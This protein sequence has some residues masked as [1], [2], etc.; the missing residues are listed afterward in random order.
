MVGFAT[1]AI[2]M[3]A[4]GAAPL[5]DVSDLFYR[6]VEPRIHRAARARSKFVLG[7]VHSSL[8]QPSTSECLGAVLD[9]SKGSIKIVCNS[10]FQCDSVNVNVQFCTSSV[11][12]ILNQCICQGS[13]LIL[14]MAF[15]GGQP[16][17]LNHGLGAT[18]SCAE[19]AKPGDNVGPAKPIPLNE[20]MD[21]MAKEELPICELLD[22]LEKVFLLAGLAS[23]KGA[24][25]VQSHLRHGQA[26]ARRMLSAS[27]C[28]S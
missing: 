1:I 17:H 15:S 12:L 14:I 16:P 26:H 22:E 2:D 23:C 27:R 19:Q 21:A 11:Q 9:G 7:A 8:E 10:F 4:E 25:V 5:Y 13:L 3:C 6:H 24:S 28:Q 20:G 18:T